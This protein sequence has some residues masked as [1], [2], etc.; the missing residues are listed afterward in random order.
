[1]DTVWGLNFFLFHF[2]EIEDWSRLHS[3]NLRANWIRP[4]GDP[5]LQGSTTQAAGTT[6]QLQGDPAA[7]GRSTSLL[8]SDQLPHDRGGIPRGEGQVPWFRGALESVRQ[9]LQ[10]VL[11]HSGLADC[12][13]ALRQ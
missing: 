6:R 7:A 3:D 11:P 4:R 8:L 2:L 12:R 5:I 9:Y 13:Q 10:Q 1:M